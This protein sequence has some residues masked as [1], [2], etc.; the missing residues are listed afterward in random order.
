MN[1]KHLRRIAKCLCPALA[2]LL[3]T[4]CVERTLLIRS[5]PIGATVY[6]NADFAGTTPVEVPFDT[7][8]VFE[9]I[10]SHPRHQRLRQAVPVNPPWHGYVPFDFLLENVFPFT[11]HDQREII[12]T[13]KSIEEVDQGGIE[14]RESELRS[15]IFKP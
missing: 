4:G 10:M 12:L 5:D 8:G 2:M 11:I 15:E 14:Q 1:R 9:I 7:Y 6:V 13:L 3:V